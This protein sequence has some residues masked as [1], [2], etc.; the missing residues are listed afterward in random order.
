MI[1]KLNVYGTPFYI[2]T[3]KNRSNDRSLFWLKMAAQNRG[4]SVPTATNISSRIIYVNGHE[5]NRYHTHIVSLVKIIYCTSF[6]NFKIRSFNRNSQDSWKAHLLQANYL[7]TFWHGAIGR[8]V[9]FHRD[10]DSRMCFG[11]TDWWEGVNT[12]RKSGKYSPGLSDLGILRNHDNW[13]CQGL[14]V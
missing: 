5:F 14:L 6:Y 11:W 2:P 13:R 3:N 8:H 4:R 1:D 10:S 7:S 12:T 9:C